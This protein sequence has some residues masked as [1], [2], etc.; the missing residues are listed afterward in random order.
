[1]KS[2]GKALNL[3]GRVLR[4]CTQ[5]APLLRL[6]SFLGF[7]AVSIAVLFLQSIY[8]RADEGFR[9]AGSQVMEYPAEPAG[10]ARALVL[11][12][13]QL[14]FRT[15]VV[16]A[17]MTEVLEH[18]ESICLNR[19]AGF[20][21]PLSV[22]SARSAEGGYVA[23]L[24]TGQASADLR[25]LAKRF[26]HFSRSGDLNALGG[27]RYAQAR[28]VSGGGATF[29]FTMWADS[30]LD[31][32][33]ML[34][35]QEGDAEGSDPVG[36]PRPPSSQRLLSS[37]EEERPSRVFVYRSPQTAEFHVEAF[38]RNELLSKGWRLHERHPSE[39]L[40]INGTK[41]VSAERDQ[42]TITVLSSPGDAAENIITILT[43]EA[44]MSEDLQR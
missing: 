4:A 12:G 20:A 21:I 13:V 32:F 30:S 43:T 6:G 16:S 29:L 19:S 7:V 36:V 10:P 22:Q 38:Y 17:P 27:L 26:I 18:Y 31:L 2:A 1:M 33:R 40:D 39:S 24:D 23:C 8:V 9:T 37:W 11:N 28:R 14:A 25:S 34:S 3:N 5:V 44:P 35:V 42:R 15:Q 41:I